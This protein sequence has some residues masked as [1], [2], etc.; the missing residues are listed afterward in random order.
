MT[1]CKHNSY[2]DQNLSVCNHPFRLCLVPSSFCTVC[3]LIEDREN[4]FFQQT[5]SLLIRK[6]I[7]GEIV[8]QLKPC[9]GCSETKQ[10]IES[11][12]FVWPYWHGGA[13][14]DELRWSIRSVE[15]F[16][17]GQAKITLI[18]DCPEWYHGHVIRKKRVAANRPNRAFRDML[19]KVW[20]MA[21]HPEI[22]SEFVWMM[23]DVYFLKPLTLQ[24]LQTPR[25]ERWQPS[26]GNS[27]QKRKSLTMRALADRG[28]PQHDYATHL[29]HFVE[30]EKLREIFDEL[31]MHNQTLLW[32]VAYGNTYRGTPVR[33]RPFFARFKHHGD[34]E[35]YR[36]LTARAKI[37]N[38][39]AEGWCDGL[40]TFL[41]E[42]LPHPSSV[43]SPDT[44]PKPEY[45]IVR[46][47]AH[48]VKRRPI[49][50]HRA[51]I[52]AQQKAGQNDG[53]K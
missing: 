20:Y 43:E 38:H 3:N 27:W 18:G 4:D 35:T 11:I 40:R 39:M 22:E 34:P 44:P 9:G 41:S 32:E 5:Q 13:N 52:E 53:T 23:D 28:R 8:P 6:H 45:R 36:K 48:V 16:F 15:T 51:Y 49:H 30:K 37:M 25:A 50:T 12:Q 46:K 17:Q 24:E 26:E 1:H 29:P 14:G 21:T 10:R 7:T 42:L 33:T 19:S 31:D 2:R 47:R